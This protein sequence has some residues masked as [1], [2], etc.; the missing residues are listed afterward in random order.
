MKDMSGRDEVTAF[1]T[2]PGLLLQNVSE[3][4]VKA[5]GT[6]T[7]PLHRNGLEAGEPV[8]VRLF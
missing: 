7:V 3:G 5:D 8:N 2:A 1:E 4:L 6:I